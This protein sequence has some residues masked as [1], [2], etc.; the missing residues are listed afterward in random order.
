MTKQ[1]ATIGSSTY[2]RIKHDIIFGLLEP[3]SKLKLDTLKTRYATSNSTLRETLNRLTSEGFVESPAQRGFYVTPVSREDLVEVAELRVLLE[4][5]ALELSITNGDTD[6][7]GNL[8]A[9]HHKLHLMEQRMQSGDQSDKEMWKRYD[10]EF[11]LAMIEACQSKNLLSLHSILYDKYLRYQNLV[12]TY[13]GEDA[14]TEHKEM[15]DAALA[16]D[17]QRAKE[18]LELHIRNGLTHTLAAM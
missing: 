12:L 14:V 3:G 4:C 8:V 15:F 5:H 11:H 1:T 13:R 9:A 18:M 6:W 17:A 16:R 10:W 7:E 2:Q